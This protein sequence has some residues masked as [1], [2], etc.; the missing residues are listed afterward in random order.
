MIVEIIV[1][2]EVAFKSTCIVEKV[3]VQSSAL[4]ASTSA[5]KAVFG[6]DEMHHFVVCVTTVAVYKICVCNSI[7]ILPSL[8]TTGTLMV[9]VH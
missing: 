9:Q 2:F 1:L 3:F 5:L 6:T 7:C 8:Y 4:L